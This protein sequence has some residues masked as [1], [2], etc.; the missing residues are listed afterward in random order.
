MSTS[1]KRKEA[2]LEERP[3]AAAKRRRVRFLKQEPLVK[4]FEVVE[5]ER[6]K[7][8][9]K[10]TPVERMNAHVQTDKFKHSEMEVHPQSTQYTSSRAKYTPAGQKTYSDRKKN[11]AN[12]ELGR[13]KHLL[14]SQR[15]QWAVKELDRELWCWGDDNEEK[16]HS[17]PGWDNCDD[18][19]AMISY[20]T[21]WLKRYHARQAR[22]EL[23]LS[24]EL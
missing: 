14:H 17:E 19:R 12:A 8:I 5:G 2:P 23:E 13:D 3:A 16:K 6:E 15:I 10:W 24:V 7:C 18:L 11:E 4:L 9:P 21:A 1:R 22:E 20:S